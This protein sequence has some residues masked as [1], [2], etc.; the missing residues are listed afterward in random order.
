MSRIDPISSMQGMVNLTLWGIE[1][2]GCSDGH[3]DDNDD[4]PFKRGS[5]RFW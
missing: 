4:Q 5:A 2:A 1:R 3:A